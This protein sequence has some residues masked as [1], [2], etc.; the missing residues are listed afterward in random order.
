MTYISEK[1]EKFVA[2]RGEE[3]WAAVQE[4]LGPFVT[5]FFTM[6]AHATF[7]VGGGTFTV[8]TE[9]SRAPG[10]CSPYE[11]DGTAPPDCGFQAVADALC[12]EFGLEGWVWGEVEKGWGYF[13]FTVE[14]IAYVFTYDG[15]VVGMN[16]GYVTAIQQ[17][18]TARFFQCRLRRIRG[19]ALI[20][21]ARAQLCET[22]KRERDQNE[23]MA[24]A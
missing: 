18:K 23:A 15:E 19:K 17:A 22:W 8:N 24:Y 6:Q 12:E 16:S 5:R 3:F 9:T 10:G 7:E 4:R 2:E 20:E 21:E 1:T 13:T 14:S 11:C